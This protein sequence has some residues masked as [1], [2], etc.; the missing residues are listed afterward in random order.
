MVYILDYI[1][2]AGSRKEL[3][4]SD[5]LAPNGKSCDGVSICQGSEPREIMGRG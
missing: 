4:L 1:F 2:L 5:R 3:V